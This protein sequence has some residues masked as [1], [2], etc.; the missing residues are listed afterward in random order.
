MSSSRKLLYRD[1]QN[2]FSC[3]E[4]GYIF[5][6]NRSVSDKAGLNDKFYPRPSQSAATGYKGYLKDEANIKLTFASRFRQFIEPLGT[7]AKRILDIGCGA[8]FFLD[9]AKLYGWD[10][11]GIE[12]CDIP[13]A[14]GHKVFKG[15]LKD[16]CRTARAEYDVLTMWDFLECTDSVREDLFYANHLI[17]KD[18]YLL[19]T[20][21]AP[22][23]PLRYLLGSD[24]SGFKKFSCRRYFRPDDLRTLL[25]DYGFFIEK[26]L[27]AGKYI[28]FGKLNVYLNSFDIRLVVAKKRCDVS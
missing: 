27:Y 23:S 6:D 2:V 24:W 17:K 16:F 7:P 12:P 9:I 3:G 8:G 14:K 21:P 13:P 18:G 25:E 26:A 1:L 28:S 5:V 10:A 19:F 4:C 22:D 15:S 11:E 20:S